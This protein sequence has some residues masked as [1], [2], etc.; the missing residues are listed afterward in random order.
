MCVD[1]LVY[2]NVQFVAIK[3]RHAVRCVDLAARPSTF[4]VICPSQRCILCEITLAKVCISSKVPDE[5]IFL[6]LSLKNAFIDE[7]RMVDKN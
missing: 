3:A 7:K 6:P 1:I 2:S 5:G 4:F